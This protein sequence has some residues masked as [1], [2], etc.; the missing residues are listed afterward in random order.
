MPRTWKTYDAYLKSGQWKRLRR[1][2]LARD[3]LCGVCGDRPAVVVHH[4]TY[5]RRYREQLED[6]QGLCETCHNVEHGGGAAPE[7]YNAPK[8]P[9][10]RQRRGRKPRKPRGSRLVRRKAVPKVLARA[11]QDGRAGRRK[12]E[13]TTDWGLR[14]RLIAEI[15]ERRRL[16]ALTTPR[17][18]VS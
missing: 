6:L 8:R 15:E 10:E 1:Q 5:V 12:L 16:A 11:Q 7:R 17:E 14:E 4:L 2:V 9:G 13:E 18:E 3:A